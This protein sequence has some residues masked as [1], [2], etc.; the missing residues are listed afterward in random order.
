MAFFCLIKYIILLDT[1]KSSPDLL[2]VVL[3]NKIK[4]VNTT[5]PWPGS[6]VN[7][8]WNKAGH[9]LLG[10]II[11]VLRKNGFFYQTVEVIKS[12]FFA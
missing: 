5:T 11:S 8:E 2:E 9:C 6:N 12:M 1:Y 4:A 7:C 10:I 3:V